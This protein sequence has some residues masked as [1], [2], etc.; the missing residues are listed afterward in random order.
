VADLF[1]DLPPNKPFSYQHLHQ[2]VAEVAEDLWKHFKS[3]FQRRSLCTACVSRVDLKKI[4]R[5][6]ATSAT[7]S[8]QDFG[9]TSFYGWQILKKI[10]HPIA[11]LPPGA[12]PRCGARS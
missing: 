3:N 8:A 9:I 4:P 5:S 2:W 11:V 10:C 7:R 6:T 12:G 1:E